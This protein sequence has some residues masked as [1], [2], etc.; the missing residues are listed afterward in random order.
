MIKDS[1]KST[2]CWPQRHLVWRPDQKRK[3]YYC[4]VLG[5]QKYIRTI[6]GAPEYLGD[7]WLTRYWG[8]SVK[9]GAEQ[10]PTLIFCTPSTSIR[11][12]L[13]DSTT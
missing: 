8:T 6:H 13:W 1:S 12:T 10:M 7:W 9:T 3:I 5:W 11:S 4:R 2:V